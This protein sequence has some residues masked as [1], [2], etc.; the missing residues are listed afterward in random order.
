M[1]K[2]LKP[3][4]TIASKKLVQA[5]IFDLYVS[6]KIHPITNNQHDFYSINS[7]SWVNIIPITPDNKVVMVRQFRHGIE[8]FCLEIPGGLVDGNEEHP[9]V[10]AKRELL[11]ETGYST[12]EIIP[13]GF[14]YPNPAV[15]NNR[16]YFYL[17]KNCKE[18]ASQNLDPAE[19]IEVSTVP[20][21][22]IPKL[23][24]DGSIPHAIILAA[25]T[26]F[27]LSK[28]SKEFGVTF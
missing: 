28:Y 13:L 25:F 2:E 16:C 20:I 10:A 3:W 19:D 17:A 15:Q 14:C 8:D 9:E 1:K 11:E 21:T 12:D 18:I 7:A 22:E 27:F 23:L 6:Q 4:V 26:R 24:E 5:R